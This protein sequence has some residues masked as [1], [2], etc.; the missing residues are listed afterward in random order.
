LAPT[1][2]VLMNET[3]YQAC[4]CP[5]ATAKLV[6]VR[7]KRGRQSVYEIAPDEIETILTALADRIRNS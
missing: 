5:E 1:G 4:G 7:G 3:T 6:D 2:G